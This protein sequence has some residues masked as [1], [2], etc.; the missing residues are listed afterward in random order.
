MGRG[1]G[2]LLTPFVNFWHLLPFFGSFC[3]LLAYFGIFWPFL[4]HFGTFWPF[5]APFGHFWHILDFYWHRLAFYGTFRR[6]FTC[7][8]CFEHSLFHS[9]HFRSRS[10]TPSNRVNIVKTP[11]Q[12]Q[13][14]IESERGLQYRARV[15]SMKTPP[16]SMLNGSVYD[17]LS[18]SIWDEYSKRR[19]PHEVYEKK[20]YLW[21]YLNEK[22][23]VCTEVSD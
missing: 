11:A 19:Q 8:A 17:K 18:Q 7:L 2:R 10:S 3:Q 9:P 1:F 12:R 6:I 13:D 14:E 5:L 16:A 23:K 15:C 21:S 22:L 4:A 20:T